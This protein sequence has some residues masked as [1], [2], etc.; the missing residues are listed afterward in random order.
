VQLMP[1]RR[2][3]AQPIRVGLGAADPDLH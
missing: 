2:E 3:I 1:E